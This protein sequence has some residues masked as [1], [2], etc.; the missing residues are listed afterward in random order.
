LAVLAALQPF[1]VPRTPNDHRSEQAAQNALVSKPVKAQN[2]GKLD[3][4]LKNY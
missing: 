1:N 4:G 2:L 3:R